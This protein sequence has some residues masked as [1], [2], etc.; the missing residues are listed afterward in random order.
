MLGSIIAPNNCGRKSTHWMIWG[1][2]SDKTVL[3]YVGDLGSPF[4]VVLV[5]N[6]YMEA[7]VVINLGNFHPI[8]Q[9]QIRLGLPRLIKVF[10]QNLDRLFFRR[11]HRRRVEVRIPRLFE[12]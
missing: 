2:P 10:V 3:V 8:K 11:W 7:I 5:V 9:N 4:M 12:L 6:C 1:T